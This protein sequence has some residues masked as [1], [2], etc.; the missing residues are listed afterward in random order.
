MTVNERGLKLIVSNKTKK[1]LASSGLLGASLIWGFAFVIV[2]N[3]FDLVPTIYM[4]AFRFTIATIA[5]AIIF[6]KKLGGLNKK[7]IGEGAILGAL[8]FVSYLLQTEGCKYTTAGKNAFLTTTYI[9][10]VPFL[11]WIIT[12]KRPAGYVLI[13]AFLA[14]AGIGLLSLQGNLSINYGDVLTLLCGIG[15]AIHLVGISKFTKKSDPILLTVLQM[16]FTAI[17]SWIGTIF[18]GDS[19][20]V[21]T[22]SMELVMAMLYL[23]LMSSA[24]GF[25]L[26]TVCQKYVSPNVAALLISTEAIFGVV[27]T[28]I[29]LGEVMTTRMIIGCT[30]ILVAIVI[31]ETKLDFLKRNRARTK[32]NV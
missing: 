23:G 27:F 12:R 5:L 3:A 4:L 30:I 17:F 15:Y 28:T 1:I 6:W 24:I 14:I 2:K 18:T 16:F 7:I 22:V 13:A 20:G 11:Y 31:I 10:I 25:L 19:F 32:A 9:I 8:L 21:I 29:F 26:Q